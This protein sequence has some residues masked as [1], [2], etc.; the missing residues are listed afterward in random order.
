[1]QKSSLASM[2]RTASTF[3]LFVEIDAGE[4]EIDN[5]APGVNS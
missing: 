3:I 5:L 2:S 1:M 4:T